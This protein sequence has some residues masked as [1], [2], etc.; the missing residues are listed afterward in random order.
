MNKEKRF[1]LKERMLKTVDYFIKTEVNHPEVIYLTPSKEEDYE[2]LNYS[3]EPP[4]TKSRQTVLEIDGKTDLKPLTIEKDKIYKL[5]RKDKVLAQR[6]KEA[7]EALPEER[8]TKHIQ[9]YPTWTRKAFEFNKRLVKERKEQLAALH[10]PEWDKIINCLKQE[11]DFYFDVK[12]LKLIVLTPEGRERFNESIKATLHVYLADH[13]F[14]ISTS[15]SVILPVEWE[16][17]KHLES[18]EW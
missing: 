5:Y 9:K 14:N 3:E 16:A 17:M 18:T 13:G 8:K 12:K 11:Y 6:I 7:L 15:K 4:E 2:F 1:E 10:T